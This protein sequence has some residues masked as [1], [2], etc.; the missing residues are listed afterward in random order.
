[1]PQATQLQ[2]GGL[3]N[4]KG[5]KNQEDAYWLLHDRDSNLIPNL[6]SPFSTNPSSQTPQQSA[7]SNTPPVDPR[8]ALLQAQAQ[9]PS[10]SETISGVGGMP[11]INPD[12]L[13]ALIGAS[14]SS[15][16]GASMGSS[17]GD[18]RSPTLERF[19]TDIFRNGTGNSEQLPMDLP[20]GP[21]YVLGPGDGLNIDLF[22][23]VSQRLK[24]VVDREGRVALP[25]VGGVQVSGR[26]VGDV[27]HMIQ[28]VLRTEFRDVQADIS[29]SRIRS[30]R[31]YVVGDVE[32]A[33]AY[34][35]SSLSTPP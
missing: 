32:R 21:D 19:G 15:G 26:T 25:E 24:R 14:M 22:G 12:Q 4:L 2:A 17:L 11:Q 33:G 29:L 23:S 20:A 16:G 3:G 10:N 13:A 7:P 34:E 35:V 18:R 5:P 6:I 28:S 1:M 27:Q 9:S 8:R 30:V 31:V